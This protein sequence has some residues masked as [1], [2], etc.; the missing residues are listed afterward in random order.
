AVVVRHARA[1]LRAEH[2]LHPRAGDL[3][4]LALRGLPVQLPVVAHPVFAA[5]IVGADR[6]VVGAL[7]QFLVEGG[8]ARH[9]GHFA[10]P[11]LVVL[12]LDRQGVAELAILEV[13][14]RGNQVDQVVRVDPEVEAAGQAGTGAG[15]FVVLDLD[16]GRHDLA[17][18]V[19]EH[20][21]HVVGEALL[22]AARGREQHADVA[23]RAE[24]VAD[25][26]VVALVVAAAQLEFAPGGRSAQGQAVAVQR[27]LG[28]DVDVA[29]DGVGVHV[30]GQCLG[31][32]QRGDDVG[33]DR[34]ELNA[35]AF[36]VGVGQL[37]AID[38]YGGEFLG[39]AAHGHVAALALVALDRDARDALGGLGDVVVRELSQQVGRH[40]VDVVGGGGLLVEGHRVGIAGGAHFHRAEVG[41]VVGAGGAGQAAAHPS[42]RIGRPHNFGV[43]AVVAQVVGGQLVGTRCHASDAELAV[44]A[45]GGDFLAIDRDH[46]AIERRAD[47]GFAHPAHD[48]AGRDRL[49]GNDAGLGVGVG[50]GDG[51]NGK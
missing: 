2:V 32:L 36:R 9:A 31:H 4:R 51:G 38:G 20:R 48:R 50:T 21:L 24:P 18:E 37:H 6:L 40:H 43:N 35:A 26:G 10:G 23:V 44:A 39:R 12:Q 47:A 28:A 1:H 3:V 42:A 33:G 46:G 25:G 22:L 15:A 8:A 16:L 45:G 17:V 14:I 7:A 34:V 49:A 30:R 5:Q 11:G 27:A 29:G 41:G 19:I 13:R